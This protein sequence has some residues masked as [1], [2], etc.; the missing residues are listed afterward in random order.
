MSTEELER[1]RSECEEARTCCS[2]CYAAALK[3][4]RDALERHLAVALSDYQRDAYEAAKRH[5]V[6]RD[7]IEVRIRRRYFL[8]SD[9]DGHWYVIPVERHEE[10]KAWCDID[11]DDEASW[12]VPDFAHKLDG[13]PSLLTFSDWVKI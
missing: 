2:D 7:E 3:E 10:W 8:D 6:E 5:A 11:R 13:S 12:E 1:L 4:H 9:D